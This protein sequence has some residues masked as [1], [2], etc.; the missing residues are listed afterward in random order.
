ME[1]NKAFVAKLGNIQPIEGA[2]K[3]VKASVILNDIAITNV[4]VG[5]ESVEGQEIVYFDSNLCLS[6]RVLQDYPDLGNYLSKNGR[7]K[8]VKL[9]GTISNGLAVEVA[10]FQKY[11]AKGTS[12]RHGDSFTELCSI[13]ICS[14]Y[15]AP[16]KLSTQSSKKGR[17][18]KVESRMIPGQ[19]NFHID[20]DQLACNVH[21]LRP[22]IIVSITSKLHGTSAI[23]SHCKVKKPRSFFG[24]LFNRPAQTE[25][26]YI[27][28]SRSVV[29][30][31]S[32]D[33]F[34]GHDIWT[35]AGEKFFK[36]K[37]YQGETVYYEI[38]GYLPSGAMIQKGYDYRNKPGSYSIAVYR[39]T[40]TGDDGHVVE[41]GWQAVKER[42]AQL[43]VPHVPEYYFGGVDAFLPTDVD[44]NNPI[45]K[46]VMV[47][48]LRAAFLEKD[49]DCDTKIPD[50]GIVLRV[51]GLGIEVY[52]LRS[53]KFFLHESK[54]HEEGSDIEEQS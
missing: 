15:V 40:K 1:N 4:V 35:E 3:I 31:G 30:N 6:Q 2:D 29:K 44:Y 47:D 5:V 34:Y 16:I 32:A 38:V 12:L 25:Y 52:K 39:I 28:A 46:S 54:A 10:K 43:V 7:V 45:W 53:E 24:K 51:E 18:G 19:F 50:E 20:T 23:V 42:C 37:L 9:R 14:K 36:G 41:Y 49:A 13:P 27:Y 26:D 33:G 21:K 8:V 11:L 22:N 17:N 48:T